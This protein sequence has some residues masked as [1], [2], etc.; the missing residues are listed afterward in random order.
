MPRI[1]DEEVASGIAAREH[2]VRKFGLN[3]IKW[4]FKAMIV[5]DFCVIEA[6]DAVRAKNALKSF[7][8]RFPGRRFSSRPTQ[9][10]ATIHVIRRVS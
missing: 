2:P 8:K 6:H 3:R 10:G 5:N 4:P 7:Y 9:P 1:F